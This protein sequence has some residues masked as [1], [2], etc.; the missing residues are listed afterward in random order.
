MLKNLT[1]KNFGKWEDLSVNF[2]EGL[3]V[4]RAANE[5]G[6]STL[7]RAIAYAFWG[8]RSLP[9]SL[10]ETVTWG[11]PVGQLKVT[12]EFYIS[13][14]L[15][16]IVRSKSGAELTG[17]GVVV[18]GHE[19]VT[20]YV[21]SLTK[22]SMSVGLATLLSNQ[23]SL[24]DSLD[25]SAIAL[26]E[27]LSN[28][29]LIDDVIVKVQEKLPCGNTKAIE[30]SLSEDDAPAPI[31]DFSMEEAA[32]LQAQ[33]RAID[34]KTLCQSL[35]LEQA[36][37][38]S[39][40]SEAK[41][42]LQKQRDSEALRTTL[43]ARYDSLVITAIPARPV[44][45]KIEA[46]EAEV[47]ASLIAGKTAR[48][49]KLFKQLQPVS[50]ESRQEFAEAKVKLDAAIAACKTQIQKLTTDKAVAEA[51]IIKGSVCGLCGESYEKIPA[52]VETNE[53]LYKDIKCIAENIAT[54]QAELSVALEV[55][56]A[57]DAVIATDFAREKIALS[58]SDYVKVDKSVIPQKVE[59]VGSEVDESS[60]PVPD[61]KVLLANARKELSDYTVAVA[62]NAQA[63]KAKADLAS[64]LASVA[65]SVA[66]AGDEDLVAEF[67]TNTRRM[68]VYT[69]ELT[70]ATNE[71]SLAKE[72]LR[73][74]KAVFE[75]AVQSHGERVKAKEFKREL[76][77]EMTRNN[78]LIKKL[79]D[80]RPVV[81]KEL[82]NLVI[83]GISHIFSQ[84]RG[85]PSVVTR[86][87]DKFLVDGK[88]AE[89]YSGSTKDAL[90]LAIRFM[91]QKTFMPN[92]DFT[93]L[94][95]PASGADEVRETAMLATMARVD[96]KQTILV[97]HSNLADTF[98]ANV[99]VL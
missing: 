21:E 48:A 40:V 83:Q 12:L 20:A 8:A 30:A 97:T 64:E 86:A 66:L 88:T 45:G 49:W 77:K 34:A 9:L 13:G 67:N 15:Y 75:A 51:S 74:A 72:R 32:V 95:E 2:T 91:S 79:R 90:G 29:S 62:K 47:A 65:V 46:L 99:V 76:V 33:S 42:R 78:A 24:S 3:N 82:W 6:K 5:Q 52:V 63:V 96:F 70:S 37:L 73:S 71:V 25:K 7:Y 80:V 69:G 1:L 56:S 11:K 98:A 31:A 4:I 94:D 16:K 22:A 14:A 26:I 57:T 68:Q 50:A 10:D 59:W 61:Y 35:E 85:V 39:K 17:T 54:Y 38:T 81:A 44:D 87:D 92:V 93:L 43:Q 19:G 27:K 53:K 84:I 89:A 60:G 28:M 55:R 18:S 41:S 58:I 23:S 36:E